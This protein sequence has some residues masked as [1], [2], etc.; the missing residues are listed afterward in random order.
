MVRVKLLF[1]I[2]L[3][4]FVACVPKVKYQ[5]LSIP[6]NKIVFPAI[7]QVVTDDNL[8]FNKVNLLKGIYVT[9]YIHKHDLLIKI[10][11]RLEFRTTRKLIDVT[12]K[13]MQSYD[14]ERGKW[15]ED[16]VTLVFDVNKLRNN[17]LSRINEILANVAL[18][19]KARRNALSDFDFNIM[20]MSSMTEVAANRWIE[21]A[22]LNRVFTWKLPLN[23]F[24]ET[25]PIL[26]TERNYKYVASFFYTQFEE[27]VRN[28]FIPGRRI[29]I[30]L[31]T[32]SDRF[33]GFNK[34]ERIEASGILSKATKLHDNL[35]S[36]RLI[37]STM[38]N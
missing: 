19:Q 9:N 12:I 5:P 29:F 32:N 21:K 34:G 3:M 31:Y 2:I 26:T 15:Q 18:Y 24:R 25:E 17:V 38:S 1:L 13:D 30:D 27:P 23:E 8:G 7:Y 35:Y 11:F 10:R 14:S 22:L 20:G 4:F 37:D 28:F 33:A 36:F 6:Q 16:T